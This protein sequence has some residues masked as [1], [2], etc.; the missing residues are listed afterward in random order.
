MSRP[1]VLRVK[2]YRFC[3]VLT[4]ESW[5]DEVLKMMAVCRAFSTSLLQLSTGLLLQ[6]FSAP[7]E[8]RKIVYFQSSPPPYTC[9][10]AMACGRVLLFSHLQDFG[11]VPYQHTK[12]RRA[13]MPK[14]KASGEKLTM[15]G[16]HPI[17][18]MWS[19]RGVLDSSP[20]TR[21]DSAIPWLLW[22]PLIPAYR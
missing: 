21:F 13:E 2:N 3:G 14:E 1:R 16:F 19:Y 10:S 4:S 18:C 6:G 12:T 5:G 11:L 22:L 20:S 7:G 15:M 9:R 8:V 17:S